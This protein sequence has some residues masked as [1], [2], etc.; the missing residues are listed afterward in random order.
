MWRSRT[1]IIDVVRNC[2]QQV[3]IV[4]TE[5]N[6][7]YWTF[8]VVYAHT[9]YHREGKCSSQDP[10]VDCWDFK[11]IRIPREKR[12]GKPYSDLI[13]S[14]EFRDFIAA[15]GLHDLGFTGAQFTWCNNRLSKARV[16]ERIDWVF[17][18]G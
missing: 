7:R 3:I 16:W 15:S 18:I 5:P 8:V 11:C 14:Q 2:P 10:Y 17:T 1:G 9:K 12:G 4:I 6:Q 13:T